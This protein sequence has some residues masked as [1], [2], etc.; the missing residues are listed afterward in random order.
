MRGDCVDIIVFSSR[1]RHAGSVMTE[2]EEARKF[3]LLDEQGKSVSK[4]IR[5][6]PRS[7]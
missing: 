7:T 3:K 2:E 5:K 6:I 4:K 1:R